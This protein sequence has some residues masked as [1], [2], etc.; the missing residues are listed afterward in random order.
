MRPHTRGVPDDAGPDVLDVDECIALLRSRPIGRVAISVGALPVVLPV[1]YRVQDDAVVF[2]TAKGTKLAAATAGHVVAFEADDYDEDGRTGWSVLVQG[3]A[4]ELTD[5]SMLERARALG[6]E[7]WAMDGA[8]DHLV[9]VRI[10]RI[11][12]RRFQRPPGDV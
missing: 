2:R 3:R 5:P 4:E 6:L 7:A 10:D 12:G 11:S 9:A 1:N 8:A